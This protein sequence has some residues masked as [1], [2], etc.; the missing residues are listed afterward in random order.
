M[1]IKAVAGIAAV[2]VLGF[3]A[4]HLAKEDELDSV[5]PII[6]KKIGKL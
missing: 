6:K 5:M 4:W 2:A 3:A 1:A